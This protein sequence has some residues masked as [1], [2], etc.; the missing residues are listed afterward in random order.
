MSQN[1]QLPFPHSPHENYEMFAKFLHIS[2]CINDTSEDEFYGLVLSFSMMLSNLKHEENLLNLLKRSI[3][4]FIHHFIYKNKNNAE[5]LDTLSALFSKKKQIK[6][7]P[8][9]V[10]V[11]YTQK[12]REIHYLGIHKG[13]LAPKI[14][15]CICAKYIFFF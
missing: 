2:S 1:Q 12:M 11:K 6:N 15:L 9:F 8:S 13:M 4:A 14:F 3:V 10:P 5:N 7:N